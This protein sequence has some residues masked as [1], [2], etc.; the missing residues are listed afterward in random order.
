MGIERKAKVELLAPAGNMEA[1]LGAIAAG[2]DAIYL[3]GKQFGAR[4]YAENFTE[5]ELIFCIRYAHLFQ[6]KVYLTVNILMKDHEFGDLYQYLKPLYEKGLDAVIVQDLGAMVKI[7]EWFPEMEIHASTQCTITGGYG[8]TYLKRLGVTRIVPARELSLKE[9]RVLKEKS[10][11]EVECFIHGAMCYCYSGQCLFSSLL[12]GRSG[13][14]GRC[15]GPCRLPYTTEWDGKKKE[16]QYPLSLK[17]MCSIEILPAL[18]DAGIDSFKIEGR[19]K[20]AEYAAGVTAIYRKYIDLYLSGKAK[21]TKDRRLIIEKQDMEQLKNLYIRSERQDGYY[22]KHNGPDM[23]TLKSPS[24]SGSSEETLKKVKEA[25]LEQRIKL[26]VS[27]KASFHVGMEAVISMESEKLSRLYEGILEECESVSEKYGNVCV[28]IKGTVVQEA[29]NAP[30]TKE[31]IIKQLGKLGDTSFKAASVQVDVDENAFYSLKEINTLRRQAVALLEDRLIESL[32]FDVERSAAPYESGFTNFEISNADYIDHDK[33]KVKTTGDNKFDK[34]SKQKSFRISVETYDQLLSISKKK[35]IKDCCQRIYVNADLVM[36]AHKQGDVNSLLKKMSESMEV[37]LAM[38]YIM[39]LRDEAYLKNLW[40]YISEYKNMVSGLLVRN[41]E[42]YAWL[43]EQ[44]YDGQLVADASL[45]H[46]NQYTKQAF[47]NPFE[48]ICL[49]Y[50]L[51]EKEQRKL[52]AEAKIQAEKIVYGRI[53]MMVTANCIAKTMQK[54]HCDQK[55]TDHIHVLTDRYKA[56]FPVV[57]KC[58]HCTNVIYNSV[59][60]FLLDRSEQWMDEVY[61]R[62]SFTTENEEE[63]EKLLSQICLMGKDRN[64][65]IQQPAAFTTGHE[66]KGVE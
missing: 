22:F 49:P 15:A 30:I 35:D 60:L 64:L 41:L 16:E 5:E 32:G 65:K 42:T 48:T 13:N 51:N 46:L 37:F 25:Y 6:K 18:I 47:E 44:E 63:T 33:K 57:T 50:E 20:K 55:G 38:P 21:L 39:R 10:G 34:G 9:I 29:Q 61:L 54:A 11:L 45:Y 31:N 7:R 3:A 58:I 17:D 23:V 19:M 1:F 62:I 43:A 36:A 12:G 59:P 56:H 66:K 2:A 52:L 26:P 40:D 4:A 24:Y 27:I 53:P 8:A 28:E 14:R